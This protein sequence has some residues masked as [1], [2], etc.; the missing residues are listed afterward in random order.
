[1]ETIIQLKDINFY[2][3]GI[4]WIHGTTDKIRFTLR[5]KHGKI[6]DD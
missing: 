5:K 1:M 6:L 4:Q 3:E 2:T